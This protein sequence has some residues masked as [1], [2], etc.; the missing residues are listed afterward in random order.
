MALVL[1]G[2]QPTRAEDAETAELIR[3]LHGRIGVLRL[4]GNYAQAVRLADELLSTVENDAS[5]RSDQ[6]TDAS[7]LLR[8]LQTVDALP[9]SM[10]DLMT[11]A[12][13]QQRGVRELVEQ[14][15]YDAAAGVLLEVIAIQSAIIGAD[16]PETA[17]AVAALARVDQRRGRYE[18]SDSLYGDALA[19]QMNVLGDAHPQIAATLD[20]YATLQQEVGSLFA[21]DSLAA[22]ALAM[23]MRLLGKSHPD[24]AKNLTTLARIKLA[25]TDNA[26]AE[27]LFRGALEIQLEHAREGDRAVLQTTKELA[28][29]LY[30]RGDFVTS[31]DLYGKALAWLVDAYNENHLVVGLTRAEMA[32][33]LSAIADYDSAA[34]HLHVAIDIFQSNLGRNHELV[35]EASDQLARVLLIAGRPDAAAEPARRAMEIR[36]RSDPDGS[37]YAKSLVTYGMTLHRLGR[38]YRATRTL[39]RAL[40]IYS[41]RPVRLDRRYARAL[42]ALALVLSDERDL[43]DAKELLIEAC[44]ILDTAPGGPSVDEILDAALFGASPY[45]L[46]ADTARRLGDVTVAWRGAERDCIHLVLGRFQTDAHREL[47]RTELRDEQRLMHRLGRIEETVASI[48]SADSATADSLRALVRAAE[49]EWHALRGSLT[50]KYPTSEGKAYDLGRIQAALEPGTAIVGWLDVSGRHSAYVVPSEGDVVWNELETPE[51]PGIFAAFVAGICGPDRSA[52][53][54]KALGKQIFATRLRPL[55]ASLRML[56]HVYVVP[57]GDMREI[58]IEA[59]HIDDVTTVS[60]LWGVSYISY[61]TMLAWVRER[62]R[63]FA[64]PSLLAIADPPFNDDHAVSMYTKETVVETDSLWRGADWRLTYRRAAM[65][66]DDYISLLPRLGGTKKEIEAI[67]DLFPFVTALVGVEA[68]EIELQHLVRTNDLYRYRNIHIATHAIPHDVWGDES[69]IML[70]QAERP[71]ML[72]AIV[73]GERAFDG[74]LTVGEIMRDW[75]LAADVVAISAYEP[76]F[77]E[78]GRADAWADFAYAMLR[79]GSRSVVINR[80]QVGAIAT[81]LLMERFYENLIDRRMSKSRALGEARSYLRRYTLETGERPYGHPYFWAAFALVGDAD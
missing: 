49:E 23:N 22:L 74:R 70:S 8:T 67:I 59:L 36:E 41:A 40:D 3:Q 79:A 56:H 37:P 77:G 16:H 33:P 4:D 75:R 65:G 32:K 63:S 26:A 27:I 34:T 50:A 55:Q 28:A 11:Y 72:N 51:D 5:A 42:H 17:R 20:D 48:S 10:R 2:F 61:A 44:A 19:T 14:M 18:T 25:R 7:W 35:A 13:A 29:L 60:D 58:P 31:A 43:A 71:D 1:E 69:A 73:S 39:R 66:R 54:A 64:S 80:W 21:A 38:D 15:D 68:S 76:A 9:D 53:D 78:G 47:T 30:R 62:G 81:R 57:S 12:E 45:A 24:V 6:V 46:L 52:A